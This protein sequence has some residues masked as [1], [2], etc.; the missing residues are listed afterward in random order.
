[1]KVQRL[2]LLGAVAAATLALTS[3]G[4]A[5]ASAKSAAG[6]T[7]RFRATQTG[8]TFSS[9]SRFATTGKDTTDGKLIGYYTLSCKLTAATSGNCGGA[10]SFSRGM[11]YF[12][13]L[14]STT[15]PTFAGKVT[16]GTGAYSG[17]T[18]TISGKA[19]SSTKQAVTIVIK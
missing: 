14:L 4:L 9:S 6:T 12:K 19:I 7:I 15:S 2:V 10:G 18:G 5:V 17:A 1:M 8:Q 11:I 3:A 16:G 13:F